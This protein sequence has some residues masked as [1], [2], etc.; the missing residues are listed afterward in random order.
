MEKGKI[1]AVTGFNQNNGL[2]VGVQA[3]T[4]EEFEAIVNELRQYAQRDAVVAQLF[5]P[6][7][8]VVQGAAL[9]ANPPDEAQAMANIQAAIPGTVVVQQSTVGQ[10]LPQPTVAAVPAAT[11]AQ[12]AAAGGAATAPPGVT[13]PGD[14]QHGPRVY[15][16]RP[17]RGKAWRRWECATPWKPGMTKAERDARCDAINVEN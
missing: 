10:P 7:V 3:D 2:S 14:C 4:R 15:V 12:P 13:Y 16:D 8:G 11:P 9:P 5:A 1:F 6:V 17:A